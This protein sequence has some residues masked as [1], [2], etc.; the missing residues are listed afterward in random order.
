MTIT[1]FLM[2]YRNP[3]FSPEGEGDGGGGSGG[4]GD[5]AG[6]GQ[7]TAAGAQGDDTA[8]AGDDSLKGAEG[9]DTAKSGEGDDD[10]KDGKK[11]DDAAAALEFKAELPEGMEDY[12]ADAEAFSKDATAWLKDNPNPS[13]SDVLKWAVEWQAGQVGDQAKALSNEFES[14]VEGWETAAKSDSEI[15]GDDHDAK[16][17]VAKTALE[18]WGTPEL[19]KL[20]TESGFGSHPE[21]LRWAYRAGQALKDAPVETTRDGAAKKSLA[22][23]LYGD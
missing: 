4:E 9:D 13:P 15:G 23:A 2:K 17:A 18:K 1:E 12:Q 5:G 21:I 7:D 14:Q 20:L 10:G 22:Q 3:L 16:V 11:D 6:G 19:T 8:P